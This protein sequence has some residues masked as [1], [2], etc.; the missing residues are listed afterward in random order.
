MDLPIAGNI[1]FP[2]QLLS[3][4]TTM[5]KKGVVKGK[6]P[7]TS[8]MHLIEVNKGKSSMPLSSFRQISFF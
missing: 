7:S 6:K 5:K 1:E 2:L 4:A 3:A 8:L